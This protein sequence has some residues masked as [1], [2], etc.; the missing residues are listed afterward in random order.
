MF[1]LF[2]LAFVSALTREQ[3]NQQTDHD[4]AT[5]IYYLRDSNFDDFINYNDLV[6]AAFHEAE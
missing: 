2:L 6:L 3:V 1:F 4:P 5:G